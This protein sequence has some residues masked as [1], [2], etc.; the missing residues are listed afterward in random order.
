MNSPGGCEDGMMPGTIVWVGRR[1]GMSRSLA[2][3]AQEH[4]QPHISDSEP[5]NSDDGW[6]RS[7]GQ[8]SIH[9][10]RLEDSRNLGLHHAHR[11][12][13]VYDLHFE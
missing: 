9:L 11:L 10:S 12:I 8:F 13:S 1:K 4:G 6:E 7:K 2:Q 5:L 3:E